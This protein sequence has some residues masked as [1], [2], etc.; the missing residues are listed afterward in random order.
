MFLFDPSMYTMLL[1]C[2]FLIIYE[3]YHLSCYIVSMFVLYMC[4]SLVWLLITTHALPRG[5]V[6]L[7]IGICLHSL[8]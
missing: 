1:P 2:T 5:N 6:H 3:L 7:S 8:R 4:R